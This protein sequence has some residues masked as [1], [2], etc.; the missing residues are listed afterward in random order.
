M[1]HEKK[2][3]LDSKQFTI[4]L[5]LDKCWRISILSENL[6]F[7][8]CIR[9]QVLARMFLS[10][11]SNMSIDCDMPNL[12]YWKIFKFKF[13]NLPKMLCPKWCTY[14]ILGRCWN[15]IP[16]RAMEMISSFHYWSQ[17]HNL[18]PM[19][20]RRTAYQPVERIG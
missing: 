17:H 18:S 3:P 6:A 8:Y 1:V 20:E 10:N 4:M 12:P 19:P 16:L 14:Q 5:C 7:K 15:V 11:I 9:K 2:R 13:S